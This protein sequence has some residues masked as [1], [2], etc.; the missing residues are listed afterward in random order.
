VK[1]IREFRALAD[2]IRYPATP[3]AQG[4][5]EIKR[6]KARV[7]NERL[8]QGVDP[9]RHLKLGPGSLSDVEW[10]VQLLQLEHAR[11]VSA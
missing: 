5:R 1:L 10:L 6:I 3:D 9:A 2:D 8:P 7:E 11:A 4:L